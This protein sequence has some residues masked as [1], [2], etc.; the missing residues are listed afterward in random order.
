ML[1]VEKYASNAV[2]DDL[3]NGK[4]WAKA[5]FRR[6]IV[7]MT[8]CGGAAAYDAEVDVFFGNEQVAHLINY[9]TGAPDKNKIYWHSS[10]IFCNAS[11]PISIK[12]TN[13]VSATATFLVLD[14]RRA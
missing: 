4:E 6:Q 9:K 1:Y 13:A 14:L 3:A 11:T 5:N 12:V 10:K 7:Q 8:L 2:G